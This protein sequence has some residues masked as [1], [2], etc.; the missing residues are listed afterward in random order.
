MTAREQLKEWLASGGRKKS[1]LA[2]QCN[3]GTLALHKW[4]TGASVPNPAGRA[5]IERVTG[6]PA[7][8]WVAK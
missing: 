2:G 1:W 4:I 8:A 6:I 7:S 3:V 5:A